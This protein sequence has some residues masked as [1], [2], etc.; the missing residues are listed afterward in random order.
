[1]DQNTTNINDLPIDSNPPDNRELPESQLNLNRTRE[2]EVPKKS[3]HFEEK[4]IE[5]GEKKQL[6]DIKETHKV[7]ILASLF[8]LLFSDLKVKSYI[9]NILINILGNSLKTTAGSISKI[10]LVV[11]SI[12]YA[13]SLY[14]LVN[15]IDVATLKLS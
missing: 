2:I 9:L 5:R 13:C 1:M 12:V 3:V 4:K 14:L 6:Y 7:I 11:Y 15:L 8:F 10:G